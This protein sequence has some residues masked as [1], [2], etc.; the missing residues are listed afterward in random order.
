MKVAV[1][2]DNVPV[3]QLLVRRAEKLDGITVVAQ[4]S[5]EDEAVDAVMAT[6]PDVV[7]L[8]LQLAQGTGL[9]V[10]SR[11]R[12]RDFAGRVF[13]LSSED[14]AL[15]AGLCRGRGAD[16]FYDKAFDFE[17]LLADLNDLSRR[18]AAHGATGAPAQI[19]LND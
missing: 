15:Y 19:P 17:Q 6:A 3:R 10:L 12:R 13:V 5:G 1:I 8:D 2:E 4:A 14:S 9:S 7:V 11:I 16:A 18:A